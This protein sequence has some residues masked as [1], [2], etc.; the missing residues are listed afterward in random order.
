[1][2]MLGV[3]LVTGIVL[4]NLLPKQDR[5]FLIILFSAG[6]SLRAIIFLSFY[7]YSI[8]HNGY[9]ELV[10]DSRLYFLKT[11]LMMKQW[12]GQNNF[13]QTVET[14]V[15]NSGNIYIL[16]FFYKL[17]GYNPT[18]LTPMSL[19]SD[20][21]INCL[22][23]T[24]SGIPIFYIAKNIFGKSVAKI[25]SILVVFYPSLVLWSMTNNRDTPNIFL[26]CVILF[27]LISSFKE[28]RMFNLA[29]IFISLLCLGTIRAYI[30]F[31]ILWVVF[32]SY[33]FFIL[34]KTKNKIGII[35]LLLIPSIIFLN[36]TGYGKRLKSNFLNLNNIALSLQT[37]NY[38]VLSQGGSVYRIYDDGLVSDGKANK[39]ILIK[40]F[41]KG[42]FYFM[43]VPFPWAV[44]SMLQILS[45]PQALIW[46]FLLFF[47]V[48]GII[49]AIRYGFILSFVILSYIFIV[50][51][52]FAV[53]EGNIGSTLRHR[54]LITPFYFIFT[55]V[56]LVYVFKR[57]ELVE[58]K[59]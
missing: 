12:V 26:V 59:E 2:V 55:S 48:I 8:S 54:D 15:G 23:G 3:I 56:G 47:A 9:G 10:P 45:Y 51:T 1:M 36:S 4:W 5:K 37:T 50:T 39:F 25:A 43:L 34:S 58:E 22:I 13:Q 53:I 27:C 33:L 21:L 49:V 30:L 28:K 38:G 46:Y 19:F 57:G 44:S 52:G 40:G 14:G 7:L 17:I 20:K 35:I 16:A 11:L 42:W 31:C 24:I 29:I 6:I 32:I 18:T 41:L